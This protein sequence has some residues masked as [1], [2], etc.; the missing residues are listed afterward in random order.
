MNAVTDRTLRGICP[1][2]GIELVVLAII[3]L[4]CESAAAAEPKPPHVLFL[5]TDDQRADTIAAL[6]N[7]VIRTPTM[8]SLARQG[9]AFRNAYCLGSNS[10]AVCQPS[11]NMLMSGRAYFRW[12]GP[13]APADAPNLPAAMRSAGYETYHQGKRGNV[14][15]LIQE[16]FETNTYINDTADRQSGEP[17]RTLV[18]NVIAFLKNRRNERPLLMYLAFGNPHDP[19]VA[20]GKYLD[21]YRRDQIPLPKNFLPLHP[22]DNGEQLV[23]DEKLAPWPRTAE[24]IRRHLHEYYA[25]IT[26]FDYHLGRLLDTFKQLDGYE[27]TIVILASDNGLAI[28]SHGLMG[29]QNL[30]EHSAKVPLIFAGPGIPHG[31]SDALVYLMDI[32]PTICDLVGTPVPA[33]LDGKSLAPVLQGKTPRVRDTLFMSYREVQRA[34]RDD[35]Y[36]LIRYPRI[37]RTQLFDLQQDPAELHNLADEPGQAHRVSRMMTQLRNWQDDLGDTLPL[38]A[39]QPADPTFTSPQSA[40]ARVKN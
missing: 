24:E 34:V 20:A 23:R 40:P 21:L 25:V 2:L 14:A 18:N 1:L 15:L 31:Q 10:P 32:F 35:H 39:T 28:G 9:F 12:K 26:A 33:G 30:Y 22:F 36:K 38:T 11:R 13:Q 27:N 17:G 4:M 16:K 6:G 8:D 3:G 37:N 5:L 29:K 7:P 19:R